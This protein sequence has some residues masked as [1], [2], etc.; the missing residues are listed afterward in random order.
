MPLPPALSRFAKLAVVLLAG[1]APQAAP[2]QGA[3][4][5]R[6]LLWRID[7]GAAAPSHVFGTIHITDPRVRSRARAALETLAGASSLSL[8]VVLDRETRLSAARTMV[9]RRGQRLEDIVGGKLFGA[10]A[11]ILGRYGLPSARVQMLKPWAAAVSMA[12][13]LDEARRQ[14]EGAVKLDGLLQ[15][16]ARERGI[17]VSGLETVA[18]QLSLFDSL[19]RPVQIAFLQSSVESYDRLADIFDALVQ[20]YVAGDIGGMQRWMHAQMDGLDPET[21]ALL[22]EKLIVTR[23]RRMAE[24][25]APRIDRGGAFIAVGALHLPGEKGV[26]NLLK[27]KGYKVTR[28]D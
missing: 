20:R 4:F 12:L 17:P 8:E 24:R 10:T 22:D 3:Q 1:A 6:G 15:E 11:E 13:P 25:A 2:A 5:D 9:L 28:V 19:S 26:L 16:T 23:N 14:A 21:V 18:E 7:A 27:D